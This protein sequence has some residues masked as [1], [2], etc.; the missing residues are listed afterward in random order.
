M[1]ENGNDYQSFL[2]RIWRVCEGADTQWRITLEDI[3]SREVLN[4]PNLDTL[5][6]YLRS[7]NEITAE[8]GDEPRRI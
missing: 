4:Y 3:R 8:S 1:H 6:E 7:L 2:L 5:F